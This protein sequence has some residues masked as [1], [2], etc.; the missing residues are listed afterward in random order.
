ML[1]L[2]WKHLLI[3]TALEQPARRVRRFLRRWQV[4]CHPGLRAVYDEERDIDRLFEASIRP[5]SNC[6]DVGAHIGSALSAIVRHAPQGKH[7]AFEPVPRK[8]AWLR[9][10]FPEVDVREVALA[11]RTGSVRFGEDLKQS[12]F[13]SIL[14]PG[15]SW[16]GE[17]TAPCDRLDNVADPACR[18]GFLKIDVE[19]AELLVLRG[20]TG[21]LRRDRP[22]I[23]FESAPGGAEKFGLSRGQLFAFLTDDQGYSI[24]LIGD[25]LRGGGPLDL[26]AFHECHVYPFRAFNYIAVP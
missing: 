6:V 8:A 4:S 7:L 10:K 24:Y 5:D 9:R 18:V 14:P 19:G 11:D 12:G 16:S 17:F 2:Y 1:P 23:L 22:A 25:Y 3:R 21:V 15:P 20:A 26:R 13:S